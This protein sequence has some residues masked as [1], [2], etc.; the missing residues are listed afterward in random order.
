M[1]GLA[2]ADE[3]RRSAPMPV[4]PRGDAEEQQHRAPEERLLTEEQPFEDR[5]V[6]ED[7]RGPPAPAELGKGGERCRDTADRA[8]RGPECDDP[9]AEQRP[10]EGGGRPVHEAVRVRVRLAVGE[11]GH[12]PRQP[13][14]MPEVAC[15]VPDVDVVV[16][17]VGRQHD[18]VREVENEHD[19]PTHAEEHEY[20][21]CP[22]ARQRCE[23]AQDWYAGPPTSVSRRTGS[24]CR[25]RR[26]SRMRGSAAITAAR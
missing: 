6:G 23:S 1:V 4:P 8:D 13:A 20:R 10:E 18:R 24:S 7:R 17:A 3:N 15:G 5:G 12:A 11:N 2:E 14:V 22:H 9:V 25:A 21:T 16:H 26:P 19:D